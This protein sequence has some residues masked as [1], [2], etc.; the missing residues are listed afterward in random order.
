M[1]R[2][3]QNREIAPTAKAQVNPTDEDIRARAHEIWLRNGCREGC[4][5]EDWLEAEQE[6]RK[7]TAAPK[8]MSGASA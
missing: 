6:L 4:D 8:T 3:H 1:A 5:M 7:E 2:K